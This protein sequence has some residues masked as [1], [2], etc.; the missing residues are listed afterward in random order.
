MKLQKSEVDGEVESLRANLAQLQA[1]L[2]AAEKAREKLVCEQIELTSTVQR[3]EVKKKA[4]LLV[5]ILTVMPTHESKR[6]AMTRQ[7][8]Y[9]LLRRHKT[10]P[11]GLLRRDKDTT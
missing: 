2:A 4:E 9:S 1:N 5:V 8:L 6:R 11:S 3:H 7:A 10:A